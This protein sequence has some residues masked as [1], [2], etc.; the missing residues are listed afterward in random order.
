[1][2][3]QS[4]QR[5]WWWVV[6]GA[7]LALS[8]PLFVAISATVSIIALVLGVWLS[9]L[10]PLGIALIVI[11]GLAGIVFLID[12]ALMSHFRSSARPFE[13]DISPDDFAGA[14]GRLDTIY[15]FVAPSDGSERQLYPYVDLAHNNDFIR[16]ANPD[17]DRARRLRLYC[18]W[19]EACPDAFLHLEKCVAGTWRP[20]AVTIV[21][22]ITQTAVA[23]VRSVDR[24]R[25]I[26]IVGLEQPFIDKHL[27]PHTRCLL[28]ALWLID[29]LYA[30]A[31]QG[32][33]DGRGGFGNALVLRHIARFREPSERPRGVSFLLETNNHYMMPALI[34]FGFRQA[35]KT[36]RG[37]SLYD[38]DD[39][40]LYEEAPQFAKQLETRMRDLK[41]VVISIGTAPKPADWA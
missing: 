9:L 40:S 20:I 16:G 26:G 31:G 10:N 33:Q 41:A 36:R 23:R 21:L 24:K 4:R 13:T 37:T 2:S 29:P 1:M 12:V 27:G 30:G 11:G 6:R 3:R 34:G 22:P 5:H 35:G 19:Y 18:S 28:I 25:Q 39:A 7:G 14:P 32:K 17:L 38:V 8:R 15:R